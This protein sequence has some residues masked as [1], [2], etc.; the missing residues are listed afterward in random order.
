MKMITLPAD[1]VFLSYFNE[2]GKKLGEITTYVTTS[3][4]DVVPVTLRVDSKYAQF[5]KH[6]IK[7]YDGRGVFFNKPVYR[8]TVFEIPDG[9]A[10][11]T[12]FVPIIETV[13][14]NGAVHV[15]PYTEERYKKLQK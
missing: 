14:M 10:P 11:I 6:E 12:I 5:Q 15:T 2:T 1:T 9:D 8:F 7:T 13:S 4:I 3:P